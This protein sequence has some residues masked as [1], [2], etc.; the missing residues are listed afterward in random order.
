MKFA[1]IFQVDGEQVLFYLSPDYSD[2]DNDNFETMHQI[3]RIDEV[4]IDIGISR[5]SVEKADEAFEKVDETHARMVLGAAR[6]M[7]GKGE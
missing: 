5:L 7:L 2:K 6:E 3:V 4:F 1:K